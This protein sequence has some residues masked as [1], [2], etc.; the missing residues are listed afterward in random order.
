MP[1]LSIFPVRGQPD[2]DRQYR[3]P[4]IRASMVANKR[5]TARVRRSTLDSRLSEPAMAPAD[6]WENLPPLAEII[7]AVNR[8]TRYYFQLGFIPKRQFPE[9]LRNNHRSVSLFLVL[10]ILSISARFSPALK[11]RYGT[12]VKAAEFFMER[13][14]AMAPEELYLEP[15]LERCQAFFLLSIAQQG[16]GIRNQ[17][18]VC[19]PNPRLVS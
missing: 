13:A 5:D 3:H 15:T 11:K 12:G 17:S 8:F 19:R 4:R 7:D 10:S 2:D 16:N 18:H 1:T 9:R 14:A 6:E